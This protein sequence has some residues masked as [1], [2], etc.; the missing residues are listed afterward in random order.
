MNNISYSEYLA[1]SLDKTINYSEY[2]AEYLMNDEELKK[3][4]LRRKQK[5]R[6][7]KINRLIDDNDND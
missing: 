4:E 1:E 3:L 7:Q 6:K 5:L 2:L